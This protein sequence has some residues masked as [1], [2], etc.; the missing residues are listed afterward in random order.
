MKLKALV[1][2]SVVLVSTAACSPDGRK[3]ASKAG[4]HIGD[5]AID[6]GAAAKDTARIAGA[7]IT[8]ASEKIRDAANETAKKIDD[9]DG[10]AKRKADAAS[11]AANRTH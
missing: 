10:P 11:E 4:D 8:A 1:L 9:A 3:D 2:L 6:A 5:A 7:H